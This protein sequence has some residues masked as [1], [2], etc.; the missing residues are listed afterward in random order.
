MFPFRRSLRKVAGAST[1]ALSFLASGCE[2][3]AD[4]DSEQGTATTV[5]IPDS[6][7][8]ENLGPE[9]LAAQIT[10][11][12]ERLLAIYPEMSQFARELGQNGAE[13]LRYRLVEGA[14]LRELA[15]MGPA[16]SEREVGS[17]GSKIRTWNKKPMTGTAYAEATSAPLNWLKELLP[18][19]DSVGIKNVDGEIIPVGETFAFRSHHRFHFRS[20]EGADPKAEVDAEVTI[21]WGSDGKRLL[22]IHWRV[23]EVIQTVAPS[24]DNVLGI[25]ALTSAIP[26]ATTLEALTNCRHEQFLSAIYR[27]P[28]DLRRVALPDFPFDH[29]QDIT[30]ESGEQHPAVSVV[31]I[32]QD[33]WDDLYVMRR[34]GT[35]R[36][37][38]NQGD[39]TFK[40]Q[41]AAHGLDIERLCSCALFADFDNDGDDDLFVGRT[42]EPSMLLRNDDGVFTNVSFKVLGIAPPHL[43]ASAAA[44]DYDG[45]GLLD[46]YI[47][48]YYGHTQGRGKGWE[49]KYLDERYRDEHKRRYDDNSDLFYNF[50]GPP[51]LLLRNVGNLCFEQA[52]EDEQVR[53]WRATLQPTWSDWDG[54]GDPDLLVTNDFSPD[55]MFRN[56]PDPNSDD[57]RRIFTDVAAEI[58]PGAAANYFGMGGSWGDYNLDGT[59]DLYLSAMFSKA[60]TRITGRLASKNPRARTSSM[61]N[62]LLASN[63][64]GQWTQ[65]SGQGPGQEPVDR[66]GW[67]WGGQFFDPNNDGRLDLY[68]P[69][70]YFTP[71]PEFSSEVDY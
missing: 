67:A 57:G 58:A 35:N 62:I 24:A 68:A 55:Q 33:G 20:S 39:G 60:G 65:T 17:W 38:I 66:V 40:D 63:G 37:L 15:T 69:T 23:G 53:S 2:D 56:D 1:L 42:L 41:A 49:T 30:F 48:T 4:L 31:D 22:I 43:V 46:L 9:E 47:G 7:P 8:G 59:Q 5:L 36:L 18:D 51:N 19:Y 3:S 70:G 44:A 50:V 10:A 11:V 6:L 13:A 34:W 32:N 26:D 21:D 28:N 12:E 54:D 16:D 61:G 64:D 52:S 27:N 14:R 25:P 71:P 45:D 29:I